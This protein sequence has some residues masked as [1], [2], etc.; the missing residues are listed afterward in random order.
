MIDRDEALRVLGID[1]DPGA[2]VRRAYLRKLREHPP[3][4]DPEGFQ[5]IRAAYERL[6]PAHGGRALEARLPVVPVAAVDPPA[7]IEPA[8][9]EPAP[10]EA[11][12]P[13]PPRKR[14]A[15]ERIERALALLARGKID[16][17]R[18]VIEGCQQLLVDDRRELEHISRAR[19]LR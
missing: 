9:V 19:L 18:D 3:E 6:A 1:A 2:D 4:R 12:T 13:E 10:A 11:A 17:A 8:P 5:R 14:S 7:A 16:R 15:N